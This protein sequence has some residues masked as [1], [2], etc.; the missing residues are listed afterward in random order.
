MVRLAPGWRGSG[1]LILGSALAG[2]GS[3]TGS[4][5]HPAQVNNR[6]GVDVLMSGRVEE[7]GLRPDGNGNLAAMLLYRRTDRF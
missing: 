1:L 4:A 5:Q 6:L 7:L 2:V 3:V